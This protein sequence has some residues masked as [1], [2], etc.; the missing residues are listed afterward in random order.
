MSDPFR[1]PSTSKLNGL[2]FRSS[3][4]KRDTLAAELEKDPQL[5]TAKRQQRSQALT[6]NMAYASLERQLA[7]VKTTKMELE[8]KVR[9]KDVLI[10]QLERD[11]RWFS[12][13]E[14]KE[15][16]EKERERAEHDEERSRTEA[17]L[18][19]LRTML[20][21]LREEHADTED[22]LSSLSRSSK[23]TIASQSTSLSSLTRQNAILT[24]SLAE[25]ER[26]AASRAHELTDLQSEL[27]V[28]RALKERV[29]KGAKD[30]ETMGVVRDELHR[31]AGHTR[32]LEMMNERL[33][34]EVRGLRERQ[35]SVEVLREEKRAL[36]KKVAG[37]EEMREKAIRLEA[38]V[39]AARRERA[40][41]YS[42]IF[43]RAHNGSQSPVSVS[44]TSALTEL[45][46]AH[47]RLLEEHGATTATL[48]ERD[49]RVGALTRELAE[50]QE[51]ITSLEKSIR[52]YASKLERSEGK[53]LLA[54]RQVGFLEAML[55]SYDAE[56]VHDNQQSTVMDADA[57]SSSML[58]LRVKQ[59]E[60]MVDEY[61]K[62]NDGLMKSLDDIG[63]DPLSGGKDIQRL[64]H[65]LSEAQSARVA[66]ESDLKTR[67]DE[68]QEQLAR[69]DKLE[70]ELFEL[71]GEV[72]GGR[73]VPPGVRVLSMKDN[74]EEKWFNLRQEALDRLR[75]EN[76]AL[77]ARLRELED[78]QPALSSNNM[79]PPSSNTPNTPNAPASSP[80]H[81]VPRESYE[82]ALSKTAALAAELAQKD[83][84]LRRL[85]QVFASKSAEF[86][87]AIASI[88]GVKLAFYPNG[89]V[90]VTSIFDLNASF[91]FQP[92]RKGGGTMQLVGQGESVSEDLL[93]LMQT[94]I[95]KEQCIPAFVALVTLDCYEKAKAAGEV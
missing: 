24:A 31:Q 44:V 90:R 82:L 5:S 54:E 50:S 34:A 49:S 41:W 91:V 13:L 3:A 29:D 86:R 63:V 52:V 78:Q 38:E 69:I 79:P 80:A 22:A 85:Q 7:A 47:A 36:E 66:L 68:T 2:P 45:R 73:H 62:A 42:D 57:G 75:G 48:R 64:K 55:A 92:E 8:A 16:E 53:A 28:L 81:L 10:E 93:G 6:S 35:T 87:E 58:R 72:A 83:T 14:K 74:P 18:R 21:D 67:L 94:W 1:T 12:D 60:E 39:E 71:S 89:Q 20:N 4:I 65:E 32:K 27:E 15:R 30:V 51:T 46:L 95:V 37:L 11:R 43:C 76:E 40:Q 23:H 33:S 77:M 88:L 19:S 84:R 59:L 61:R 17:E 9:E 25:S 26:I 70:Q 56:A